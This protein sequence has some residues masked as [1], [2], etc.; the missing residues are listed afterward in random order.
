MDD[1]K[2][3]MMDLQLFADDST[4][5]KT[6]KATPR[7]REEARKKGQ[8][9]KS[10]D[11]SSAVILIAG[12]TVIFFT[13]P[14]ISNVLG[15]FTRFC[16]LERTHMELTNADAAGLL[17]EVTYIMGK[18]IFPILLTTFIAALLVSYL[19]VGF[20][21]SGE[22]LSPKL[23]RINPIQGFKNKFSK[24]ALV[25]LVKSLLKISITAYIVFNVIKKDYYIFPMFVD[26][27]LEETINFVGNMIFN[28]ALKVGVVFIIIGVLDY[29][30]QMYEHEKSLMMSKYDVKQEYKQ[31]EGDPLIKSKQ[32]QIQREAAMKR[33]MA[34][35]PH[36]DVVITNPTHFAV[37][38]KYEVSSMDAPL[39]VAKGQDY[40]ALRI[41]EIAIENKVTIIENPPLTRT[42]FHTTEIGQTVPEEL[43]QAVAEVLA[44]VYKQKKKY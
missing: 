15:E 10:N 1:F 13:F 39:L 29:F 11:L 20:L 32:R 17:I 38:L 28:I 35:V 18:I 19:Q 4:G 5:E 37:A 24:R 41:R 7:R 30:Y 14:Y 33:M 36:A 6:E 26:M 12:S 25:E 44:F 31:V 34:E 3:Y 2:L 40:L 43:Y 9:F 16:F 42:L 27:S 22:S 23:E 21:I 8:V